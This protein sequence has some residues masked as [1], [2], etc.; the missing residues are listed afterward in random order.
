MN[1]VAIWAFVFSF[2]ANATL[3]TESDLFLALGRYPR[4]ETVPLRQEFQNAIQAHRTMSYLGE[5][6]I[7]GEIMMGLGMNLT[8]EQTVPAIQ[9]WNKRVGND[10]T[11]LAYAKLEEIKKE[12][13]RREKIEAL[14]ALVKTCDDRCGYRIAS[15][16]WAGGEDLVTVIIAGVTSAKGESVSAW[17]RNKKWTGKNSHRTYEVRED[18]RE[19][20]FDR[21][22]SVIDGMLT[23]E[24]TPMDGE[25]G[26]YLARWARQGRG[27]QLVEEE[28]VILSENGI[29]VHGKTLKEAR[30]SLKKRG[31]PV[32]IEGWS[33]AALKVTITV[34]DSVD[35][36][37]C[38]SGT[39]DWIAKNFPGRTTATVAEVLTRAQN[40]KD[41]VSLVERACRQ[42]CKRAGV[43]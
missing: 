18:W 39:K 5:V 4:G 12:R 34:K 37:N 22:L 14:K 19:T 28:G 31:Q 30:K 9:A 6:A 43:I 13:K 42:A 32:T 27:F 11:S 33:E 2:S 24:A 25:P 3:P 36:G 7:N 10:N 16:S 35:A 41:R 17:S 23:L 40:N 8:M 29:A 26:A 1:S 21:G 38:A 15:G 20:V